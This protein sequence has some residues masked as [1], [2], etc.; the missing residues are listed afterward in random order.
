M[1]TQVEQGWTFEVGEKKLVVMVM[2][3]SR[4]GHSGAHTGPPPRSWPSYTT[5]PGRPALVLAL[6]GAGGSG[7]A[8]EEEVRLKSEEH[9]HI[10]IRWVREQVAIPNTSSN[11]NMR[12]GLAPLI[13]VTN[14]GSVV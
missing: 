5:H 10:P 12:V 14:R 7:S 4:T 3:G 2:V 1:R 8:E 13:L 9:T 11:S 6:V